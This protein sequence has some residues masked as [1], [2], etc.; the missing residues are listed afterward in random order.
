MGR[1]AEEKKKSIPYRS[2]SVIG[3]GFSFPR[4]H[5]QQCLAETKERRKRED[6][7]RARENRERESENE[8]VRERDR[9]KNPKIDC[10]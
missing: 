10:R 5:V 2:T 3:C 1:E 7:D 4:Y 8:K 6:T 9:E